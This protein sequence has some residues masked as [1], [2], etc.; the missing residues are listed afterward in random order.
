MGSQGPPKTENWSSFPGMAVTWGG[1]NKFKVFLPREK[2]CECFD[3]VCLSV[4][5]LWG[6][7]FTLLP[8]ECITQDSI[9]FHAYKCL[10]KT[11]PQILKK[12]IFLYARFKGKCTLQSQE[13]MCFVWYPRVVGLYPKCSKCNKGRKKKIGAVLLLK[14]ATLGVRDSGA[15]SSGD[16]FPHTKLLFSKERLQ[17]VAKLWDADKGFLAFNV[18]RNEGC[19]SLRKQE[20]GQ[21]QGAGWHPARCSGTVH[22]EPRCAV[23]S[24]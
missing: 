7:G 23:A 1:G 19:S 21:K 16:V 6:H 13:W 11:F 4:S 18:S 17:S 15:V 9:S 14:L 12:E 8:Y 3:R 5:E 22:Q 10:F 2:G 20:Q 24:T